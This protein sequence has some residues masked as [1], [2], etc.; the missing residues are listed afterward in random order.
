MKSYKEI[1]SE[2]QYNFNKDEIDNIFKDEM[3]KYSYL[4]FNEFKSLFYTNYQIKENNS[5]TA[6][7]SVLFY[8]FC[9]N[10]SKRGVGIIDKTEKYNNIY[11]DFIQNRCLNGFINSP[12]VMHKLDYSILSNSF[13]I[14][15][16]IGLNESLFNNYLIKDK[17][18]KYWGS[19]GREP[20]LFKSYGNEIDIVKYSIE[21][22]NQK[23][24]P[25]ANNYTLYKLNFSTNLDFD[26]MVERFGKDVTDS[27]YNITKIID[28][29][30]YNQLMQLENFNKNRF[31]EILINRGL[32]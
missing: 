4:S 2:N 16:Y 21:L 14:E 18:F 29:E 23:F 19:L 6:I 9:L 10:L 24:N 27:I 32:Q 30:N 20:K 26:G 28:L 12:Q 3:Q 1:F 8:A 22:I 25:N 5:T 17:K 13:E 31:I 15:E 11:F 7:L